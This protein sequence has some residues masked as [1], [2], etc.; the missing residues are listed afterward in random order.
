MSIKRMAMEQF[1]KEEDTALPEEEST[2]SQ[3]EKEKEEPKVDGLLV[4][5]INEEENMKNQGVLS[6][7]SKLLSEREE[8][9]EEV[10]E[11]A[12][13]AKD[14]NE[15]VSDDEI[16]S[17]GGYSSSSSSYDSDSSD[18]DVFGGMDDITF[19]DDFEDDSEGEDDGESKPV[20]EGEISFESF[21]LP[22]FLDPAKDITLGLS[23]ETFNH[24]DWGFMSPLAV[25]LE[26][27][28]E[29]R[30]L[31]GIS[32]E[33]YQEVQKLQGGNY[34][35]VIEGETVDENTL[36]RETPED[37]AVNPKDENGNPL[38]PDTSVAY[39]KEPI[40]ESL[41]GFGEISRKYTNNIERHI[42]NIG[43]SL[44]KLQ[45][46][47]INFEKI[48]AAEK[49]DFSDKLFTDVSVMKNIYF[50]GAKS[51]RDTLHTLRRYLNDSAS[52]AK[53][54]VNTPF[55][56][57]KDVFGAKGFVD[58]GEVLDYKKQVPGFHY[59]KVSTP[60]YSDYLKTN[61]SEFK[62]YSVK[63]ENPGDIYDIPGIVISDMKDVDY[64][65]DFMKEIVLSIG[66]SIDLLRAINTN[67]KELTDKIKLLRV[68]V[69]DDQYENLSEIGI[70]DIVKDFILLKL[71]V[72]MITTDINVAFSF[73][74][75]FIIMMEACVIFKDPVETDK[76]DN[77][78]DWET[79]EEPE[80]E[81]D[82]EV[83]DSTDTVTD[84]ETE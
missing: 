5:R 82:G 3:V 18:D 83:E 19:G 60:T 72:E 56:D 71:T 11:A 24:K 67:F 37:K 41:T 47:L 55:D 36:V 33:S 59:I 23:T 16:E 6:L 22:S 73:I 64:Y 26:R 31:F 51:L 63:E 35:N 39:V 45:E 40:I 48:K 44:P 8:M 7:T 2:K 10:I 42:V 84:S 46:R 14:L 15:K 25:T 80:E 65:V 9:E 32:V 58:K 79:E 66:T 52:I 4:D 57:I 61:P 21:K 69:Q 77:P 75:S 20:E 53:V 76:E 62:Y 50:R 81:E 17:G 13:E 43:E 74:S 30:E 27:A 38:P 34:P 54:M 49:I 12:K 78:E 70:D 68:D 28:Q 1:N 29:I